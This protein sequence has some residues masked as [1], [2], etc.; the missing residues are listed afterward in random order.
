MTAGVSDEMESLRQQAR[1]LRFKDAHLE[2]GF[3]DERVVSAL[4]RSRV[5]LV[6]GM[7][8][9]GIV[10]YSEAMVISPSTAEFQGLNL[11]LRFF[12]LIPAWLLLLV[13]TFLPGHRRRADWVNAAG[14]IVACWALALIYWH[15]ARLFPKTEI[16]NAATG[17]LLTVLLVSAVA[18]PMSFRALGLA[19]GSAVG[20]TLAFYAASLPAAR[21]PEIFLMT[22]TFA[23]IGAVVLFL[24]WYREAGD[25]LM[26]AQREHMRR[27]NAALARLNAEKNEFIAIASHDLQSPLASVHGLADQLCAG[28]LAAPGEAHA[29]IRDLARRMLQLVEDYLGA[30]AIEHGAAPAGLARLDL[31]AVAAQAAERFAPVAAGKG[32]RIAVAET[33]AVWVRGDAARLAQVADNFMSNALKFSPRGATVRLAVTV[34]EDGSAARMEV[35]DAGPGIAA[36]EQGKLF[37]KFSRTGA[38]PT[39]GE[40]SHGLGLAVAKRL[41]ETMGGTVGCDSA[42]GAGATFWVAL[43]AAR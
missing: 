38:Q 11:Q 41:A 35:T 27:L 32:Q 15:A 17:G 25:R 10:G 22:F 6:A 26:F 31:A 36:A 33:P 21:S 19:V 43:P 14:T 39:G 9:A 40:A 12:G 4:T 24:S 1:R 7:L 37:R 3:R 18:L 2:S 28:R 5:L 34:A 29:A 13:S 42:P 20:G 16:A 23:G 8:A 30:H